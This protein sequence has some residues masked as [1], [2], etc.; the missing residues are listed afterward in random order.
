MVIEPIFTA[1][2]NF[3]MKLISSLMTWLTGTWFVVAIVAFFKSGSKVIN[4]G[5]SYIKNVNYTIFM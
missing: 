3:S 4:L 5:N 2:L 1:E